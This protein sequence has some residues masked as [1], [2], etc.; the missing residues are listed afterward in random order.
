MACHRKPNQT[1]M[2]PLHQLQDTRYSFD[3]RPALD[4]RRA[5]LVDQHE[6][7]S[8]VPNIL[9]RATTPLPPRRQKPHLLEQPLLTRLNYRRRRHLTPLLLIHTPLLYSSRTPKRTRLRCTSAAK[10]RSMRCKY[11][12]PACATQCNTSD[13]STISSPYSLPRYTASDEA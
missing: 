6:H 3:T 4:A 9:H 8:C 11:S 7:L 1:S 5:T 13:R 2:L 12:G 10:S